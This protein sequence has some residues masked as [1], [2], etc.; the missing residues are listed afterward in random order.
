MKIKIF[1]LLLLK[2]SISISQNYFISKDILN[3]T[4][5]LNKELNQIVKNEYLGFKKIKKGDSLKTKIKQEIYLEN[6]SN[7]I[8]LIQSYRN[9]IAN[10]NWE[11]NLLFS[12]EVFSIAKLKEINKKNDFNIALNSSIEEKINSM[13]ETLLIELNK[14]LEINVDDYKITKNKILE[15]LKNKDSINSISANSLMESIIDFNVLLNVNYR[16]LGF[17]ENKLKEKFSTQ[18]FEIKTSDGATLSAIVMKRNGQKKSLPVIL[19]NNIYAGD[20][21]LLFCMRAAIR[22]YIGVVVNTRGKRN[23]TD[24]NDPFEHEN[25]DIYDVIEWISKQDWCNGKV[26]MVGGSYLGFSQWAATKKLHPALKTIVPQVAV[27]IGTMDYPM[28]NNVFMSYSLRW[29]EYVMN[30]KFINKDDF[31]NI[32]KWSKLEKQYYDL[33]IKFKSLDSLNGKKNIIFQRW[34]KHPSQDDFWNDMIPYEKE[35]AKINIPILS[36]TGYWDGDQRGAL[37]YFNQHYKYNKNAEHYLVIGPYNHKTAQSFPNNELYG[38]KLDSVAK[39]NFIKLNYDWFDYILKNKPKPKFLKNK[40]NIQVVGTNQWKN[41]KSLDEASNNSL[42]FYI[43][44]KNDSSS[45]FKKSSIKSFFKQTIDFK[46]RDEKKKYYSTSIDSTSIGVGRIALESE[47]LENDIIINGS[48][49]GNLK[50]SINKKDLDIAIDLIQI[51]PN[52]EVFYL[53]DYIGRASYAKDNTKR[54]LL[55]PNKIEEIP[56]KNASFVSKKIEKGSK[57]VLLFGVSKSRYWQINY[58]TG[59]DVSDESIKDADIPL[60]VKWYNDSYIEIPLLK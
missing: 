20:K 48:F 39:V 15:S 46:I 55:K 24:I 25:N 42:R 37:F 4:I 14:E 26:G 21:D 34:L 45:V 5:L 10:N 47:I 35:F 28:T 11:G 30:S 56:V 23:S 9:E 29:L 33:G 36:S 19:T 1:L 22:D 59:R 50:L 31:N 27:G 57:L 44:K 53:S 58:G 13:D 54:Q 6:F 7:A 17:L 49:T 32:S 12:F 38:L 40:V 8:F 60:E 3:D 18:N 2:Y 43:D 51:K 41:F 52:G 16:A